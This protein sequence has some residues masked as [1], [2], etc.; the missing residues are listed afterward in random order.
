[1]RIVLVRHA[2]T[3]PDPATSHREWGL[4]DEGRRAALELRLDCVTRLLAGPEPRMAATLA[5]LGPVQVD[6][7]FRESDVSGWLGDDEFLDAVRRYHAGDAPSGW[8]AAAGV[9][10]RFTSGFVDGAAIA[11]GGRAISAVV[12]ALTGVDGFALWR[13]L[14]TPDV[15]VLDRDEQDRWVASKP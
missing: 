12:A 1:V 4:S 9:V 10:D 6:E 2:P 13:S 11:S 3:A 14:R 15:I 7:R 8:E 5:H